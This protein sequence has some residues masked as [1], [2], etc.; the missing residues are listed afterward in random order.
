MKDDTLMEAIVIL[1]L[2]VGLLAVRW[3]DWT[4]CRATQSALVCLDEATR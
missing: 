3:S 2:A 1:A 4:A